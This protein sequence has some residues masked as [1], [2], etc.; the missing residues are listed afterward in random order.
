MVDVFDV[1][2]AALL[3]SVFSAT[4]LITR[5]IMEIIDDFRGGK[6]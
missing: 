3:L 4:V 5:F 2:F 6:K 1:A